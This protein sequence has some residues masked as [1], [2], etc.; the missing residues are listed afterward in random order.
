[1]A[2]S[3]TYR[4]VHGQLEELFELTQAIGLGHLFTVHLFYYLDKLISFLRNY[5]LNLEHR[6]LSEGLS[7]NQILNVKKKWRNRLLQLGGCRYCIWFA[8]R[9]YFLAVLVNAEA[10]NE[11]FY[12]LRTSGL[13]FQFVIYVCNIMMNFI[14]PPHC[15]PAVR[16][17]S[18]YPLVQGLVGTPVLRRRRRP[19]LLL[20]S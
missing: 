4:D 15:R 19:V 12:W 17:F 9:R 11:V 6:D 3:T 7:V 13:A 18:S 1:M 10:F 2:D 20:I 8:V 16:Q 5:Y 14:N